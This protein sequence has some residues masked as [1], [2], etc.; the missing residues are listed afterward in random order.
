MLQSY[1]K[2]GTKVEGPQ[3]GAAAAGVLKLVWL[4]KTVLDWA[5]LSETYL[6]LFIYIN[7]LATSLP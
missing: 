3:Q 2:F 1:S 7:Q 6:L 5:G 4:L